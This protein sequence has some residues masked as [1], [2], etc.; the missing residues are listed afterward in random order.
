M[1]LFDAQ[2]STGGVVSRT[3]TICVQVTLLEQASASSQTRVARKPGPQEPT[4][5]VLVLRMRTVTFV[6]PQ[7]SVPVGASKF[8]AVPNSMVLFGAQAA[9]GGVVST[10]RTVW[11]AKL[12]LPQPSAACQVRVAIK[13]VPHEPTAFVMVLKM[14]GVTTPRQLSEA[15]GGSKLHGLPHSTVLLAGEVMDGG[16]VSTAVT[17]CAQ[18]VRLVQGS[19]ISQTRVA[20]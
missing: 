13:V 19:R 2:V 6:P 17:T 11:L 12:R 5:L 15:V 3:V 4:A 1:F 8:H 9:T 7:K 14:V 10:I 16:V 18:V 20:V